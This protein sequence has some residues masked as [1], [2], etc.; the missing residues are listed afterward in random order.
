MEKQK[1]IRLNKDYRTAYIKD[2]RRFLE[3]KQDNPKYEA[4]LSAKTLC[5]T[6]I[7]D[8]FK[9]ATKVVH[10]VYNPKDVSTLQTLQKKYNRVLTAKEFPMDL[11]ASLAPGALFLSG[12]N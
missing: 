5:K 7:D 10:R 3:S 8:A 11:K 4:Y 6:R 9:L 2:F 1:D 12:W